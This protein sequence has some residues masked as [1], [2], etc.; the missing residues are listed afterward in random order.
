[1]KDISE[2]LLEEIDEDGE[3][4]LWCRRDSAI[5][6]AKKFGAPLEQV[7]RLYGVLLTEADLT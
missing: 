3:A 5:R 4:A 6:V 1:M 7:N 2:L